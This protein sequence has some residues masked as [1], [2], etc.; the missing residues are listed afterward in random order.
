[1][2]G[3]LVAAGIGGMIG[4]ASQRRRDHVEDLDRR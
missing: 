4:G 2:V 3:A 1:V